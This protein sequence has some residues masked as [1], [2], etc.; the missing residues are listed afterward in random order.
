MK[1]VIIGLLAAMTLAALTI[2]SALAN[3]GVIWGS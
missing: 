2:T 3:S 1:R